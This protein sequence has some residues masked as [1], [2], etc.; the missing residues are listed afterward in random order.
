MSVGFQSRKLF[1]F[2]HE[3]SFH[4]LGAI[5]TA[6]CETNTSTVSKRK[7]ACIFLLYHLYSGEVL[8][9]CSSAVFFLL[10]SGFDCQVRG[11][12]ISCV[13]C[14]Q[15]LLTVKRSFFMSKRCMWKALAY[16]IFPQSMGIILSK[17]IICVEVLLFCNVN[18]EK[19]NPNKLF[20][21]KY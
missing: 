9:H 8:S 20:F 18:L 17:Y 4:L 14:T 19:A 3:L 6:F 10:L 12:F 7:T 5:V 11:T 2:I 16:F 13:F 1:P 15:Q 21:T